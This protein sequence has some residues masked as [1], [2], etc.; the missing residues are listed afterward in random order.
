MTVLT[1]WYWLGHYF[2]DWA[3]SG[4]PA[5]YFSALPSSG[6]LLGHCF[7]ALEYIGHLLGSRTI[8]LARRR[9]F[10]ALSAVAYIYRER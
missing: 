4:W 9:P 8:E 7:I 6:W 5:H 3:T 2:I 1:P 10:T